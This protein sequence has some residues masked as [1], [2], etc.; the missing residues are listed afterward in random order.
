MAEAGRLTTLH[1]E[2]LVEGQTR[3]PY[4]YIP[5]RDAV[6]LW[7]LVYGRRAEDSP[8]VPPGLVPI[9]VLKALREAFDGIPA[10]GVLARQ[11]FRLGSEPVL[12][13]PLHTLVRVAEK[14]LRRGRSYVTL[15]YTSTD[16]EGTFVA[17]S[18]QTLIW[19]QRTPVATG[20]AA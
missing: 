17:E 1:W 12:G 13:R 4:T 14:Y 8:G 5:D 19:P 9:A 18:R 2:D 20:G 3:G 7:A 11:T 10:G 16:Q 15:V 6:A